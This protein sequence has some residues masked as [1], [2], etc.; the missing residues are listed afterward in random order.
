MQFAQDQIL[1][2]S[3][4]KESLQRKEMNHP[5]LRCFESVDS[6]IQWHYGIG[7]A[8]HSSP[9][10]T[11]THDNLWST[12]CPGKTFLTPWFQMGCFL[13]RTKI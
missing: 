8:K 13:G 3:H 4:K 5:L 10:C 11:W 12:I 9:K 6:T 1:N 7:Q 2:P